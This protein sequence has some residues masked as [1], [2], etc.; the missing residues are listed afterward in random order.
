MPPVSTAQFVN[1]SQPFVTL[2]M[3]HLLETMI[4]LSILQFVN[5]FDVPSTFDVS[6]LERS[7]FSI[8][9]QKLNI[10]AISVTLEVSQPERFTSFSSVQ[11]MN[12]A[13]MI[14]ALEV[15]QPER[16]SDFRPLQL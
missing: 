16:F 9:S 7:S 2:S 5:I 10:A 15:F 12:M 8:C 4:V 6:K 1:I 14:S 3:F 13:C 11:L